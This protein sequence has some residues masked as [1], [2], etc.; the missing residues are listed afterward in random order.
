[1]GFGKID[2]RILRLNIL[3]TSQIKSG[4]TQNFTISKKNWS[5]LMSLFSVSYGDME[6]PQIV[7]LNRLTWVGQSGN[8]VNQVILTEE[9]TTQ[10]FLRFRNSKL[11]VDQERA[12]QHGSQAVKNFANSPHHQMKHLN[13]KDRQKYLIFDR[14][15]RLFLTDTHGEI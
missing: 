7:L 14:V 10:F 2:R 9:S 15:N 5:T 4:E 8:T 12:L 13:L 6:Y 3:L 1:M 11:I